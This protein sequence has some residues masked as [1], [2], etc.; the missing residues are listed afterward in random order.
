MS[1]HLVVGLVAPCRIH[2][3]YK[4]CILYIIIDLS[5][6]MSLLTALFSTLYSLTYEIIFEMYY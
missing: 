1:Q 5:N 3:Y 4:S 6:Q 2:Y